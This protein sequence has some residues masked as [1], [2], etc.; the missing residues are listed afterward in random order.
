M[1]EAVLFSKQY[2]FAATSTS[3]KQR[4]REREK[5]LNKREDLNYC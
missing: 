1:F 3:E 5:E 2:L 4:E